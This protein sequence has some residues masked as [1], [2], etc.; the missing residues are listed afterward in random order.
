[1]HLIHKKNRLRVTILSLSVL[2]CMV[3]GSTLQVEANAVYPQTFSSISDFPEQFGEI[4][5]QTTK[6]AR[7]RIYI[8]ANGHRSAVNGAS[9]TRILQAQLE[10][11]RIGE[12]LI[13]QNRI[14]LLLPE[15]FFGEW[16]GEKPENDIWSS[17]DNQ[18]LMEKLANTS[19]FVNAEVLLHENF[20]IGLNQIEDRTLYRQSRDLLRLSKLTSNLISSEVLLEL[21]YLQKLRTVNLLQKAPEI[22]D[23]AHNRGQI[24]LPNAMLT[25]GLAHLDELIAFLE[26]DEINL[27][28][29]ITSS[30]AFPSL[31]EKLN[32]QNRNIGITVI[33]P[34]SLLAHR[35]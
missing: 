10:T 13:N 24:S 32:L 21:D 25:I 9:N 8:I 34:N 23:A 20:G 28:E 27:E 30:Y 17:L 14:E 2:I 31:K 18:L 11:F 35:F 6:E 5:Y 29:L 7:S 19:V 26:A 12:W 1:M 3:C 22:V 15:G 33:V 4:V 16:L